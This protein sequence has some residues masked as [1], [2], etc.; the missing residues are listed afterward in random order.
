MS[1]ARTTEST[2]PNSSSFQIFMLGVTRSKI[3][4]P[5][6]KPSFCS[7][8]RPSETSCAPSD[9]APSMYSISFFLRSPRITGPR[10][11][12]GSVP[13]PTFS[14]AA[15]LASSRT[16]AQACLREQC[17]YPD[18]R[19]QRELPR[20]EYENDTGYYGNW[21]RPQQQNIERAEE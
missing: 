10:V 8:W 4:G 14:F 21:K 20:L 3:V 19:E 15:S 13:G 1:V 2:G 16:G 9:W 12:F 7:T 18:G 17:G 11:V 6:K 5:R